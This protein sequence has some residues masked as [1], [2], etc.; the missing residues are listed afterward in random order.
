MPSKFK[1]PKL[2]NADKARKTIDRIAK[3]L[4]GADLVKAGLPKDSNP[5]PDGT[6]VI[7]VGVAHEFGRPDQ[8]IPERSF[9]RSTLAENRREIL[10]DMGT[11]GA[12]IALGQITPERALGQM[13]LKLQTMVRDTI[14]NG[15]DPALTSR[16]G[17]PLWLSGHLIDSIT[18]KV[19]KE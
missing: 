11:V 14:A 17:T 18:Y 1:T 15:I 3:N 19:G 16:E 4:N 2:V 13:G 9:L 10:K 8:G 12:R 7:D 5:Y 6:S